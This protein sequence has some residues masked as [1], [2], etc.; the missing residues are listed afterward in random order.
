MPALAERVCEVDGVERLGLAWD[1]EDMVA[2]DDEGCGV[3]PDRIGAVF[4]RAGGFSEAFD[5]DGPR[6]SAA[7][8]ERCFSL[9]LKRLNSYFAARMNTVN[10]LSRRQRTQRDIHRIYFSSSL[11]RSDSSMLVGGRLRISSGFHIWFALMFP[12]F[13]IFYVSS[14][15]PESSIHSHNFGTYL[16]LLL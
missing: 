2:A 5:C 3:V 8:C 1:A 15:E 10:N 9:S 4:D 14:F 11:S 6:I 16:D 7:R 13:F 12:I